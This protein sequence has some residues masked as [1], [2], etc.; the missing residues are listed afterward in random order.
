LQACSIS[1]ERRPRPRAEGR[2]HVP[3]PH[4]HAPVPRRA[5]RARTLRIGLVQHVTVTNIN[6]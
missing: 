2:L 6:R 1:S 5:A 3:S 4:R